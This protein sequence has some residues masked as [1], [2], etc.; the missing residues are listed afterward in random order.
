[1]SDPT[2]PADPDFDPVELM[3]RLTRD[4]QTRAKR[5]SEEAQ[6]QQEI[7]SNALHFRMNADVFVYTAA[8]IGEAKRNSA[9]LLPWD[10][11]LVAA[12]IADIEDDLR[13]RR[14]GA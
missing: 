7:K 2:N 13:K 12:L 3:A 9:I 14:G 8:E 11:M 6:R 10:R 5:I 4:K 1:M